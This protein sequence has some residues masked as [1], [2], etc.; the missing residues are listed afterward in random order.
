MHEEGFTV[1]LQPD[2]TAC[3]CRP[4]GRPLPAA[5]PAPRWG[6]PPLA[7]TL[8]HL[9]AAGITIGAETGRPR[10]HGERLDETWAIDVLWRPGLLAAMTGCSMTSGCG[11]Y[12]EV[13]S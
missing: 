7:P 6:G 3:F 2:G 11:A 9:E 12:G 4:D 10:W 5:P 13:R 1:T 8:A